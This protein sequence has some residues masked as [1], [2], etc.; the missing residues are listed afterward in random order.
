MDF[1]WGTLDNGQCKICGWI[2]EHLN[3]WNWKNDENHQ[4]DIMIPIHDKA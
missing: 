4:W 3:Y 2:E 1:N